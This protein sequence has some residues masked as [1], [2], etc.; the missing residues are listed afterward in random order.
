MGRR[1][2][3]S[4]PKTRGLN[5]LE[6]QILHREVLFHNTRRFYATPQNVLLRWHV[7]WFTETVQLVQVAKQMM[8]CHSA[9]SVGWSKYAKRDGAG[10]ILDAFIYEMLPQPL[11][12]L[13]TGLWPIAVFSLYLSSYREKWRWKRL[14]SN[15]FGTVR[16][17]TFVEWKGNP[18]TGKNLCL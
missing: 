18:P 16:M 7:V 10:D 2:L 15:L 12:K 8:M 1:T 9:F 13:N 11:I 3:T 4:V 6:V 14:E 5:S 17:W